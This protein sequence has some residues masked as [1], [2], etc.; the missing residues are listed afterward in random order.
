MAELNVDNYLRRIDLNEPKKLSVA[1]LAELQLAHMMAVPFENLDVFAGTPVRT[2]L[3]WSY[4]KIVDGRRGGWCFEI[5]GSYGALLEAIGFDVSYHSARVY[6]PDTGEPGPPLDHLCLIVE[7][8]GRRW[9]TDP[10][11]GDSSVTPVDIDGGIQQG[12]PRL[13]NIEHRSDG[14]HYLEV[15]GEWELQYLIEPGPKG[16]RDFQPRSDA[17][18]SEEDGYFTQKPFATRALDDLGGR[19]WLLKD[20]LK[21][22][23]GGEVEETPVPAGEWSNALEHWFGIEF[24]LPAR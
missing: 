3:D 1:T 4:P 23:H 8:D 21:I 20:R 15:V 9:L 17:L 19:V 7:V 5:N 16:L 6:D 14:I 11:F 18:A 22:R 13:M 10:G 2:G 24:A 12:I